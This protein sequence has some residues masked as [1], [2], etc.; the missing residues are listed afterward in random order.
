LIKIYTA[1]THE[2]GLDNCKSLIDKNLNEPQM[3]RIAVSSLTDRSILSLPQAFGNFKALAT[4]T[5]LFSYAAK[6]FKTNLVDPIDK[7]ASRK[8]TYDKI[9]AFFTSHLF[10]QWFVP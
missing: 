3:V 6:S 8:K 1:S 10:M 4:H 9:L 7:P 2:E 5:S